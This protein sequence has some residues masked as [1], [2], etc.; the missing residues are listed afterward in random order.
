VPDG[1]GAPARAEAG[2][3][4]QTGLVHVGVRSGE[5]YEAM[6]SAT[7]EVVI[8]APDERDE[9]EPESA[10]QPEAHDTESTAGQ[11]EAWRYWLTGGEW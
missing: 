10:E 7:A 11:S 1:P 5:R 8:E 9:P 2:T 4:H 3:R 6:A